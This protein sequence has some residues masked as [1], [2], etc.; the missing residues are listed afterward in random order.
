VR[1]GETQGA[2]CIFSVLFARGRSRSWWAMATSKQSYVVGINRGIGGPLLCLGVGFA[3][4]PLPLQL[5]CSDKYDTLCATNNVRSLVGNAQTLLS[6]ADSRAN[7]EEYLLQLSYDVDEFQVPGGF[8]IFTY[9]FDGPLVCDTYMRCENDD[10]EFC[11]A[12]MPEELPGWAIPLFAGVGFFVLLAIC[13]FRQQ[14]QKR[15]R[16]IKDA[17]AVTRIY[18]TRSS[19]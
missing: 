13:G 9:S 14:L 7:F 12:Y 10:Q 3:D 17:L 1:T 19:C 8:Y 18:G 6:K 16:D 5:P 15:N 11:A 2:T 4:T